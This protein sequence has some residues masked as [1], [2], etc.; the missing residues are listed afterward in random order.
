MCAV[1]YLLKTCIDRAVNICDDTFLWHTWLNFNSLL[2][3]FIFKK[4]RF[5][6]AIL[7]SR[8]KVSKCYHMLKF[9]INIQIYSQFYW[10]EFKWFEKTL[11]TQSFFQ[12]K[13]I[14]PNAKNLLF[15]ILENYSGISFLLC[16]FLTIKNSLRIS[17]LFLVT[18]RMIID[19]SVRNHRGDFG[20][21]VDFES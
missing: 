17:Y 12:Q 10:K 20:V 13:S 9:C 16:N 1:R 6:Y 19:Q 18:L 3:M 21:R 2:F 14:L 11:I 15:K 5:R 4:N 8:T 7:I